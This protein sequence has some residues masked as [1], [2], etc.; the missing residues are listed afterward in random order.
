M[1]PEAP[2]PALDAPAHANAATD[3]KTSPLALDAPA[4]AKAE[5][6]AKNNATAHTKATT[7]APTNAPANALAVPAL[8]PRKQETGKAP[9]RKGQTNKEETPGKRAVTPKASALKTATTLKT[10]F[11]SVN[12]SANALMSQ[13][14][15]SASWSWANNECML[16][17]LRSAH[18]ALQEAMQLDFALDFLSLGPKQL[19]HKWSDA[20]QFNSRLVHFNESVGPLL[21]SL[22]KEVSCLLRMHA[23]RSPAA[24]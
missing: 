4:H 1:I 18:A 12:S 17:N 21:E 23:A 7:D 2:P 10:K 24:R 9:K 13:I 11:A 19:Q 14:S 8:A 22:E 20:D 3:A 15:S 6:N 5:K 16:H